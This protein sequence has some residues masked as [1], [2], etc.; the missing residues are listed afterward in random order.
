MTNGITLKQTKDGKCI[1][2]GKHLKYH[3]V[4]LNADTPN[5]A[6]EKATNFLDVYEVFLDHFYGVCDSETCGYCKGEINPPV[7][8][9][10]RTGK[11]PKR[12]RDAR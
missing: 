12:W 10:I 11:R 6:L 5:G 2:G 9:G 7:V 1:P 8:R 4:I 3:S